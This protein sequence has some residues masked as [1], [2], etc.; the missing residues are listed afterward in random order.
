MN[1]KRYHVDFTRTENGH[2]ELVAASYEEALEMAR[3][4]LDEDSPEIIWEGAIGQVEA[5][6][7]AF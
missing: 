6:L 3:D 5:A 2:I 4:L 1:P 7:E